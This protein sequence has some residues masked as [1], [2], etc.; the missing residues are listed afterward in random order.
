MDCHS[1]L[2]EALVKVQSWANAGWLSSKISD[3]ATS[4]QVDLIWAP[5]RSALPTKS[6]RGKALKNR[7]G[8]GEFF[9]L[10]IK[11]I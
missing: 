6:G 9:T 7:R 3:A 5:R 10:G 8:L 1:P 2:V 4:K 11:T